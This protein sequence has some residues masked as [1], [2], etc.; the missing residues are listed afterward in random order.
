[1]SL[2]RSYGY[3]WFDVAADGSLRPHVPR[4]EYVDVRNFVAVP[5]EKI[6]SLDSGAAN[7]RA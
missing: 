1:M 4:E 5:T 6:A 7:A 3:E 2:L